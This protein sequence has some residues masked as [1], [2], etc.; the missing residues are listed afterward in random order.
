[1][2]APLVDC[3]AMDDGVLLRAA[4]I[5]R[6]CGESEA[7]VLELVRA[8]ILRTSGDEQA[9]MLFAGQALFVA[10]RVRRLQRDLGVN[11]EGAA[12]ALDLLERIDR[13]EARL[14]RA[15]LD[16]PAS[17]GPDDVSGEQT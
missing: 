10:R 5:A 2:Q 6:A 8:S 13:L 17:E 12:L 4:D 7:W 16:A 15:G 9:Q 3:L 11:L 1:M 14:R